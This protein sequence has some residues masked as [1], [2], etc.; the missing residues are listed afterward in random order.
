MAL[1]RGKQIQSGE[2]TNSHISSSAS[3]DYSK[4]NLT[5][6][7]TSTDLASGTLHNADDT[8]ALV[9]KKFALFNQV[10]NFTA[11]GGSTNATVAITN[12]ATVDSLGNQTTEGILT[13]LTGGYRVPIRIKGTNNPVDDGFGNAVYAKLSEAAG[14]YTLTYFSE[15]NGTETPYTFSGA[16]QIDFAFMEVFNLQTMPYQALSTSIAWVDDAG[17]TGNHT[18]DFSTDISNRL[19]K[20]VTIENSGGK[21]LATNVETALE[22]LKNDITTIINNLASTATTKGAS[23]VGIDSTDAGLTATNVQSALKELK[24]AV[25]NE[26]TTRAAADTAL[27]TN[28]SNLQTAVNNNV[29]NLSSDLAS[30]A[31]GKGA[32][33]IGVEDA[34]N[35]FTAT[36]VEG[37]LAELQ[38]NIESLNGT[39]G[40]GKNFGIVD[41]NGTT[42]NSSTNNDTLKLVAGTN[43]NLVADAANKSVT[44]NGTVSLNAATSTTLG[45]VKIGSNIDVQADG[46]IST[47]RVYTEALTVSSNGQTTFTLPATPKATSKVKLFINGM[48]QIIGAG[49]DYTV[50]GDTLTWLNRHFSLDTSDELSIIF[51]A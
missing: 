20:F 9:N 40:S 10:L 14:V 39:I 17:I 4:L 46:T 31:N 22:E 44:I 24:Q 28:I 18:H 47:T 41:V 38:G 11:N 16:T 23:L 48:L 25:T 42:I 35:K 13:S 5:G 32:S 49:K 50:T 15:I 37:V 1:I 33:L 26:A 21:F 34:T 19:A 6:K 7:I 27:Q 45:G 3:I 43:I 51:E 2:L 8:T 30:T 36:N 29:S 12:V